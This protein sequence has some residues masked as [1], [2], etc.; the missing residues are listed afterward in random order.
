M[1]TFTKKELAEFNGKDGK[2]TYVALNG[3]VYDVSKSEQW[4]DGEH[5][6]LHNSGE[7]LTDEIGGAP[8]EEDVL[9]KFPVV[10]TLL[11]D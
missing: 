1:R 4:E 9:E 3:K 5:Q 6:F 8:H 11:K 2:P 10:G 7:D